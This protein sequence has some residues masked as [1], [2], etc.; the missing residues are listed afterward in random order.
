MYNKEVQKRYREK[1]ADKIKEYQKEYYQKTLEERKK[2]KKEYYQRKKEEL[3]NNKEELINI[4]ARIN[5]EDYEKIKAKL[6][7]EG[8]TFTDFIKEAIEEYLQK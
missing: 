4:G 1:V 5:K 8:S 2:Y 3:K 6:E 7:A